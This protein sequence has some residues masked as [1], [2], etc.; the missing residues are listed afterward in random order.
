[1]HEGLH[2]L[3][4]GHNRDP[5]DPMEAVA[6]SSSLFGDATRVSLSN[7]NL[8]G[9]RTIYRAT[10]CDDIPRSIERN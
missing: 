7:C 4:L 6:A 9:L 2:A 10:T 3:G 5:S 1:L 8:E